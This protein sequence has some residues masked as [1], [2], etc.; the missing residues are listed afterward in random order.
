MP[1]TN[2]KIASGLLLAWL[3]MPAMAETFQHSPITPI[4]PQTASMPAAPMPPA[5]APAPTAMPQVTRSAFTS[6]IAGR[7]PVDQLSHISAGQQVYYFT[8]LNGLQGHVINH[9]WERDGAF[10]LGLQ[11]PVTGSPWRV[12]SS[13]SIAVNLPGVWTVTVQNDDGSI[14]KRD[15]LVVDPVMPSQQP[16]PVAAPIIPPPSQPLTAIPP[17]LQREPAPRP[18]S[19]PMEDSKPV[20]ATPDADKT[21]PAS[22]STAPTSSNSRPIWETLPR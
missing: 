1:N 9:R 14:L 7:E 8:E 18:A 20:T 21:P 10:Q 12:N 2:L 19:T 22:T 17:A 13:K 11:F 3:A 16:A 5:A 6:A 4:P 15:T